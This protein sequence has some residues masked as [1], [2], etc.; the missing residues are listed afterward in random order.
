MGQVQLTRTDTML[1]VQAA[2]T[3]EKLKKASISEVLPSTV[4]GM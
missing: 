3:A 2:F 1:A 4:Y